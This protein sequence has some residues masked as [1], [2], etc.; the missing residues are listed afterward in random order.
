MFLLIK[1][2][3]VR[4]R[5]G[6]LIRK[7]RHG[8]LLSVIYWYVR[9]WVIK[10]LLSSRLLSNG[11]TGCWGSGRSSSLSLRGVLWQRIQHRDLVGLRIHMFWFGLLDYRFGILNSLG[12]AFLR[13]WEFRERQ[14]VILRW[15]RE[16]WLLGSMR[17]PIMLRLW[18]LR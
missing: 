15:H 16:L 14:D 10:W 4:E 5:R 13:Q 9:V 2:S 7:Y 6:W 17:L 1:W 18:H 11:C 8:S 12:L 3:L